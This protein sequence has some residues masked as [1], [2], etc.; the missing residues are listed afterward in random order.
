[1]LVIGLALMPTIGFQIW[2]EVEVRHAREKL[3][4][5]EARRLV[6]LVASEQNQILQG[7]RQVLKSIDDLS[8]ALVAEPEACQ[9]R[10]GK[11]LSQF[12][13][14]DSAF[15]VGLNGRVICGARPQDRGRDISDQLYFREALRT[16]G[17]AVATFAQD[18]VSAK[19]V[20]HLAQPYHDEAGSVVG[21]GVL[22]LSLDWLG[23]QL[24]RLPLPAA[25][26]ASVTDSAGIVL[27]RR[28]DAAR[29]VGKPVPP[30]VR[31]NVEG[32]EIRSSEMQGFD[33][34]TRI[35]GWSPVR[36][37]AYGVMVAVGLDKAALFAAEARANLLEMAMIGLG[38][39]LAFTVT[40]L[41][42]SRLIRHPMSKLLAAA[43]RWREGELAARTGLHGDASE[44]GQLGAAFDEMAAA[45]EARAEVLRAAGAERKFL[46]GALDLAAIM[47]RDPD[48][49]IRYWS[50]GC[51]ALYGYTAEEAIGRV[52]HELLCTA[53][54]VPLAEIEA[55]LARDGDWRGQLRHCHKDG[56][57]IEVVTHQV[58]RRNHGRPATV[59]ENNSDVTAQRQ[60]EKALAA[61]QAGRERI[62]ER[63]LEER[64]A[65]LRESEGRYHLL[66]E[67]VTDYAIYM[68][69]PQ[70]YVRNWNAGA[71]RIK[72]Y[73]AE[74]IV[75]RHF[76]RFYTEEDQ[77]AGEPGRVLETAAREG[78]YEAQGW[79]VRKGGSRFWANVVIDPIRAENGRLI[80]FAKVTRDISEQRQAQLSL[81]EAQGRLV[82]AQ[83]MEAV[84]QL[85]GGIAHDF[86]NLLQAVSGNLDLA[87]IT[88]RQGDENRTLRLLDDAQRALG[89]GARLTGQL[90]A[91]SRRQILRPER[92]RVSD[93]LAETSELIRRA[94]GEAIT[95]EMHAEQALWPCY[96]DASQFEAA[97]LNLVLN[98][99]DAM[100]RGGA[101]IIGM[102]NVSISMSRAA[103][104]NGIAPGDYVRI[105]VTDTGSGM[106]PEVRAHVFE[107]FFTTKEVGK[108]SGLGL[109]QVH[110]FVHQSG[111]AV[112]IDSAPGRGTRVSLF[113][114]R[115]FAVDADNDGAFGT[116]E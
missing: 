57:E 16:S 17:F 60:A 91:F 102:S 48:G 112:T 53:H 114:P 97:I 93:L 37:E 79:R 26:T 47:L 73:T 43:G 61:E 59:V 25:A 109:P 31:A 84:G 56:H 20:L 80:G 77:A 115:A 24:D 65:A 18:P 13:R 49:T 38:A 98:A 40:G 15:L 58:L 81:E 41:G 32:T 50:A 110:G 46:L 39:S 9:R 35:V 94:L 75:G 70:G 82:R 63:R 14:Y 89:R 64:T 111:G 19:A 67:S 108:G 45:L 33:G 55:A 104:L 74:E 8:G 44:F 100:P 7:A 103:A 87:H 96:I 12:R 105:D 52:S 1:M 88:T 78:R 10:L 27:A 3:M 107:P 83:K 68:L 71:Q 72:G 42:V 116:L 2:T 90:L 113:F 101:S 86:N 4:H 54:P 66:V 106:S 22:A 85:T 92:A 5:E 34:I 62:L 99:R 30:W 51:A 69:D 28:P 95:F 76:S 21:I 29:Y 36:A 6:S 11:L 23:Q